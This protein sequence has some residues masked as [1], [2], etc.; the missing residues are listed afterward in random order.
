VAPALAVEDIITNGCDKRD[1]ERILKTTGKNSVK[2]LKPV[3]LL[4]PS[5]WSSTKTPTGDYELMQRGG[6]FVMCSI[7]VDGFFEGSQRKATKFFV[8]QFHE[9]NGKD[10]QPT[11][12]DAMAYDTAGMVRQVIDKAAPKS[13][14]A[15]TQ[16]LAG[17]KDFDGATG[18]T[19]F[20]DKREARKPLFLLQIDPKGIKELPPTT[21]KP[22]G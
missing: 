19:R 1:I 8:D 18:T 13:R 20:D 21:K 6:K 2:E 4:G 7:Y 22:S 11:L 10:S 16:L 15:M 5:T 9:V 17:I 14:D 12:L 3:V